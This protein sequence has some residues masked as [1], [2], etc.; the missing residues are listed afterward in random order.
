[1]NTD[2]G[3]YRINPNWA[4]ST[5][6][7]ARKGISSPPTDFLK[8]VRELPE[9]LPPG[10]TIVGSYAPRAVGAVLIDP[11]PPSVM[12][13]ET[14]DDAHLSFINSYYSGWLEFL[15]VPAAKIGATRAEREQWLTSTQANQ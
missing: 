6:D 11:G 7:Q 13:V 8:K 12:I 10:C 5:S 9:K 14:S 2:L 1:M 15:W 3:Y 4:A